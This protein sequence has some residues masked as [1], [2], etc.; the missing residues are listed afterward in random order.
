M[1]G[2]VRHVRKYSRIWQVIKN[3]QTL[4]AELASLDKFK[5]VTGG[6][7]NHIVWVD[8]RP[9]GLSGGKAEKILEEISIACNKNTGDIPEHFLGYGQFFKFYQSLCFFEI[10]KNKFF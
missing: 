8:M 7:D 2:A 6:T 3:A 4:A 9:M 1:I 5:I 10:L